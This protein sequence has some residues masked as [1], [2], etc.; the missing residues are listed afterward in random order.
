MTR[1][2]LAGKAIALVGA[3]VKRDD[4]V[5]PEHGRVVAGPTRHDQAREDPVSFR[6]PGGWGCLPMDLDGQGVGQPRPIP[7]GDLNPGR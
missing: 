5:R 1:L 7:L 3:G 4:R 2:N 6:L